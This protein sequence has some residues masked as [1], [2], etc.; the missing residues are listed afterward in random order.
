MSTHTVTITAENFKTKVLESKRPVIIDLWAEW[1][2]P[3]KMIAPTIDKIA[4]AHKDKVTV[5]KINID[6][7]PGLATELSVMN[8]PTVIFFKDGKEAG[9]TVGVNSKEAFEKKIVA[10]FGKL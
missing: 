10:F 4:E 8:I 7:H 3:C 9:R 2:M 6:D 1:C 5:G